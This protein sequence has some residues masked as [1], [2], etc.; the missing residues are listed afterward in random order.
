MR[1]AFTQGASRVGDPTFGHGTF[2]LLQTWGPANCRY[3]SRSYVSVSRS[4]VS[5][6]RSYVSVSRSYVSVSCCYVSVD[7][8]RAA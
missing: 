5:V 1:A 8:T 6:S 4:Y 3:G 7:S 2:T